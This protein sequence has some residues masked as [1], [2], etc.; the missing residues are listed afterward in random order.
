MKRTNFLEH[1]GWT[2]LGLVYTVGASGLVST[3][4][5]AAEP[6][7]FVQISD[8]HLGFHNAP[9]D[10]VTGTLKRAIDA[11]NAM[12]VQPKFVIHTGDVTHLSK[13]EQF[14]TGKQLLGTLKAP[15]MVLP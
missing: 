11:V 6:F 2:G 9:N 7:T 5:S 15:L 8:S 10:D 1:V 12:P 4:A 3:P 13:P 14:D